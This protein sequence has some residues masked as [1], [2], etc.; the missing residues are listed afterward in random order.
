MSFKRVQ[1]LS[2]DIDT[3]LK[4]I[5]PS[6]MLQISD[7]RLSIRRIVPLPENDDSKDRTIYVKRID[8]EATLDDVISFFEKFGEIS[9]VRLRKYKL[10]ENNNNL[11]KGSAFVEF[12]NKEDAEKVIAQEGTLRWS[13]KFDP[14]ILYW[15]KDY[16]TQKNEERKQFKRARQQEEKV[17]AVDEFKKKFSGCIVKIE[18]IGE[19]KEGDNFSFVSIKDAMRKLSGQKEIHVEWPAGNDQTAFV[20]MMD[21]TGANT[22]AQLSKEQKITLRGNEVTISILEGEQEEKILDELAKAFFDRQSER[23]VK[24]FKRVKHNK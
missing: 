9:A 3:I 11:F 15:K 21:K 10:S 8:T 17:K 22:A 23:D 13:D 7:D 24:K 12:K 4:S 6:K 18:N 19:P 16:H 20:R 5:E 14:F 1:Q 2:T